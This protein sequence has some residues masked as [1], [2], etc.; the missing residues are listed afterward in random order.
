M[1]IHELALVHPN[2]KIGNN[3]TIEAFAIIEEDVVI[4]DETKIL[5]NAKICDGARIG[6]NCVIH[7]NAVIA[8]IPQDLKFRGEKSLAVI[9]DYVSIRECVT[10]N[11]GTASRG[12]TVVG[13]NCLLMAYCH[14]AHDSVLGNSVIIG[15]SV[16]VAG[17]VEIDDFAIF[18]GSSAVHQFCKVGKHAMISGG[19]FI[20]KDIPPFSRAARHI[21]I[22]NGVN[23]IGLK[24]RGF[25]SESINDILETYRYLYQKGLNVSDAVKFIKNELDQSVVRDEII[26]FIKNSN[27]GIV[28]GAKPGLEEE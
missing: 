28:R 11:R 4:G 13:N 19:T 22:F 1:S 2:A 9:G 14:I 27:R 26:N 17:E 25:S 16:Q 18:G 23:A 21:A 15:N 5:S 12:E 24:R 8:G 10:V 7:P 20:N 3:V 6:K